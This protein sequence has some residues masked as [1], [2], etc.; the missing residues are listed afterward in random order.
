MGTSGRVVGVRGSFLVTD[1]TIGALQLCLLVV[2]LEQL[3][4]TRPS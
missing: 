3:V 2:V 4:S 1:D